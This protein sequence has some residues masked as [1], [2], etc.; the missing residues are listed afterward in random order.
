LRRRWWRGQRVVVLL[1]PRLVML[2]SGLGPRQEGPRK[3]DPWRRRELWRTTARGTEWVRE[4]VLRGEEPPRYGWAWEKEGGML[5]ERMNHVRLTWWLGQ[6]GSMSPRPH[7]G[8]GGRSALLDGRIRQSEQGHWQHFRTNW[9]CL[10]SRLS[11]SRLHHLQQRQ[12]GIRAR[13]PGLLTDFLHLRSLN[14]VLPA[15][16]GALVRGGTG[17]LPDE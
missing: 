17:G 1:G 5:G 13:R 15:R 11:T 8:G 12:K 16:R 9:C 4:P 3:G 10:R 14:E 7:V 2:N 6:D